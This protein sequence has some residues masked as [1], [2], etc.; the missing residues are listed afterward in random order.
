[1]LLFP[2]RTITVHISKKRVDTPSIS[3]CRRNV[4]GKA[5]ASECPRVPLANQTYIK[6]ARLESLHP[7][8]N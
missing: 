2:L 4:R 5:S 3:C 1:M 8:N 6:S 7:L